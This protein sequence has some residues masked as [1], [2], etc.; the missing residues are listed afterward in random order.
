VG[1]ASSA[2]PFWDSPLVGVLCAAMF[3]YV[4][5]KSLDV[6]TFLLGSTQQTELEPTYFVSEKNWYGAKGLSYK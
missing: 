3:A 1:D 2:V 4:D 5:V 6:W